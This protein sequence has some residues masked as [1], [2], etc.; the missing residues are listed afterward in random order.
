MQV[1]ATLRLRMARS[2]EE[3][4]Q[5]VVPALLP[6]IKV[7]ALRAPWHPVRVGVPAKAEL[8]MVPAQAELIMVPA[9]AELIMVV[10]ALLASKRVVKMVMGAA[11]KLARS[12]E[13]GVSE[14]SLKEVLFSLGGRRASMQKSTTLQLS[15]HQTRPYSQPL[16]SKSKTWSYC[17]YI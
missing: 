3:A 8:I 9:K 6:A 7:H 10:Q 12:A 2:T 1:V 15:L 11:P 4:L 14:P 17:I 5:G 16:L 13:L